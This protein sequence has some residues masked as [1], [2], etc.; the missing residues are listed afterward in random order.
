MLVATA[1][2]AATHMLVNGNLADVLLFGSFQG[3]AIADLMSTTYR[4][5]VPAPD[6]SH[7]TAERGRRRLPWIV[8]VRGVYHTVARP[9]GWRSDYPHLNR[10]TLLGSV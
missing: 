1:P 10:G 8:D 9:I 6:A 3:W 5:A 2:W 7:P 4:P